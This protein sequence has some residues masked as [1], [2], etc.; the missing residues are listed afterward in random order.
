MAI[1]ATELPTDRIKL[2]P[3]NSV[4]NVT[5]MISEDVKF[6]HERSFAN[7][8]DSTGIKDQDISERRMTKIQKAT[9]KKAEAFNLPL[10]KKIAALNYL[11]G[12]NSSINNFYFIFV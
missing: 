5:F 12:K 3:T 10:Q 8:D 1:N 9:N 4:E 6:P 7:L 11:H 2:D